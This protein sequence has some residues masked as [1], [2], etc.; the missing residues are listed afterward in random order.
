[1]LDLY[2][3][4][5]YQQDWNEIVRLAKIDDQASREKLTRY[6]MEGVRLSTVAPQL[7]RNVARDAV[8]DNGGEQ[9]HCKEGDIIFLDLVPPLFSV[10]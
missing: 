2:L 10:Y 7:N 3:S 5:E 4:D 6:T 1:L 8:V 9:V